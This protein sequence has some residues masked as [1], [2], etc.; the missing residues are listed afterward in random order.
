MRKDT[1]LVSEI[2]MF[3]AGVLAVGFMTS[4]GQRRTAGSAATD[5]PEVRD[6]VAALESRVAGQEAATAAR[7]GQLESRLDEHSAK[8]AEVPSTEQIVNAMEQLLSKT[9][10]S[11]DQRLTTQAHS[12]E[13]LKTTVSQTDGLLERVLESLDSLQTFSEP[14]EGAEDQLLQRAG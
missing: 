7:L 11:L 3:V 13:V 4:R 2:A 14:L 9:M 1:G 10:S 5:S 6:A 12:I 8:L